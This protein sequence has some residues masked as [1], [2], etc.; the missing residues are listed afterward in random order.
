MR[1]ELA[2]AILMGIFMGVFAMHHFQKWCKEEEE[3]EDWKGKVGINLMLNN[4]HWKMLARRVE[5]IEERLEMS[6]EK[7]AEINEG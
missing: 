7:E 3:A 2:I 5:R 4:A 6:C 1:I